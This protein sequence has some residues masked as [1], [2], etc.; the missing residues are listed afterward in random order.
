MYEDDISTAN[1]TQPSNRTDYLYGLLTKDDILALETWDRTRYY[2]P[3]MIG[4]N[5]I[6]VP[7]V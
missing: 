3:I 1:N 6:K 7:R 5:F 2:A 4:Q